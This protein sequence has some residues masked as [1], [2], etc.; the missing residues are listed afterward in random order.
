M[1]FSEPKCFF[2][3]PFLHWFSEV[4]LGFLLFLQTPGPSQTLQWNLCIWHTCPETVDAKVEA[5]IENF[6][7]L[8]ERR[9]REGGGLAYGFSEKAESDKRQMNKHI[10]DCIFATTQQQ[11]HTAFYA[12]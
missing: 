8:R 11:G 7:R 9:P 12:M 5:N 1:K 6:L 3:L 4:C 2:F 10:S